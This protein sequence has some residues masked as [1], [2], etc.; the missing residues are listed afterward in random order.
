M[1]TSFLLVLNFYWKHVLITGMMQA[2][3]ALVIPS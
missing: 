1:H 3:L 2:L